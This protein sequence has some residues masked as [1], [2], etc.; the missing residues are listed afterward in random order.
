MDIIRSHFHLF[1]HLMCFIPKSEAESKCFLKSKWICTP[2]TERANRIQPSF[3]ILRMS[4]P[5][6]LQCKT[7]VPGPGGVTTMTSLIEGS[8]NFRQIIL[9]PKDVMED[10]KNVHMYIKKEAIHLEPIVPPSGSFIDIENE[11]DEN[12]GWSSKFQSVEINGVQQE[13]KSVNFDIGHTGIAVPQRLLLNHQQTINFRLVIELPREGHGTKTVTIGPSSGVSRSKGEFVSIGRD[14]MEQAGIELFK[15]GDKY[16]V[17][18]PGDHVD[19]QTF[20]TT[21]YSL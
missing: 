18:Y 14:L 1:V 7:P 15:K 16:M 17:R 3:I 21:E 12:T 4:H 11:F 10:C 19:G 6:R 13:R 2:C 9:R 5:N 8:G 20:Q